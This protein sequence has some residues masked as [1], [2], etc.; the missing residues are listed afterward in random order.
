MNEK[1]LTQ[2]EL[3]SLNE[4]KSD[5]EK[6]IVEFGQLKMSKLLLNEQIISLKN[7]EKEIMEE[8]INIRNREKEI[9]AKITD[10]Y[11]NGDI[12]LE[13]GLIITEKVN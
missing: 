9:M 7:N 13:K 6:K 1:K 3:D 2:L 5:L 4:I 10:I 12:N 11:G 8:Y